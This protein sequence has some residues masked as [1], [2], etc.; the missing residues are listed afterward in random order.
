[1]SRMQAPSKGTTR[2]Q[3]VLIGTREEIKYGRNENMWKRDKKNLIR[4]I[5]KSL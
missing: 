4:I 3:E 1:M 2:I 5:K